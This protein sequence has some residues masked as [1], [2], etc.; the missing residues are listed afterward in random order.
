MGYGMILAINVYALVCGLVSNPEF[1]FF[2][3]NDT[4]TKF[5]DLLMKLLIIGGGALTMQKSM[6]LI[7]N[8]VSSGAGSNELRDSMSAGRLA[9]M[10]G[11]L[12]KKASGT[13]LSAVGYA[14]GAKAVKSILGDAISMKSRDWG[15]KFLDKIGLGMG[16]NTSDK[17]G[18]KDPGGSGAKNDEK[19]DYGSKNNAKDAINGNGF[20][21]SDWGNTNANTGGVNQKKNNVVDNAINGGGT[22]KQ[23]QNTGTPPK[24]KGQEKGENKQ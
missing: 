2:E 23:N 18:I 16:G 4:L 8:L 13:A 10:A 21:T 6:A 15:S 22:D 9:S 7:G 19:A 24:D 1:A 17:D 20:K 11:G 12:A 3:G 5:L 14:T